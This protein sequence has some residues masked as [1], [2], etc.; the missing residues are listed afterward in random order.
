MSFFRTAAV[1]AA[2]V[3]GSPQLLTRLRQRELD[4]IVVKSVYD[5]ATCDA[6]AAKLEAGQHGLIRTDFPAKFAAFFYGINLN[7]THPDLKEYFAEVPRFDAGL[8]Q[9]LPG[10]PNLEQRLTALMSVLD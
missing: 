4:G 5:R 9:L 7:L 6:V 3:S 8:S 10:S 2:Q 1:T